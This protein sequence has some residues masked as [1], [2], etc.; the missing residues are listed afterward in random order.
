MGFG[1]ESSDSAGRALCQLSPFGGLYIGAGLGLGLQPSVMCVDNVGLLPT[2]SCSQSPAR[3]G[4]GRRECALCS[5]SAKWLLPDFY[6]GTLA[7][8]AG[9]GS[10][11]TPCLET[12]QCHSGSFP[13]L[14]ERFPVE[15][16]S[17]RQLANGWAV[18]R[19][20]SGGHWFPEGSKCFV[21]IGICFCHARGTAG[22]GPS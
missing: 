20:H 22:T 15:W 6:L 17:Q 18:A 19:C 16:G 5:L 1:L 3:E 4:L 21:G 2:P 8:P 11:A 12:H 7:E 9:T 10:V 14:F 13:P